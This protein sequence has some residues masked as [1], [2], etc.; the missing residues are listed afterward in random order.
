M[1]IE[2]SALQG[3]LTELFSQLAG[4]NGEKRLEEFKL[5]LKRVG[6][7]HLVEVNRTLTAEEAV[8]ATGRTWWYKNQEELDSAPVSG[9]ARVMQEIFELD[10]DPTPTELK[11]EYDS[12]GLEPDLATLSAYMKDKPDAADERPIACKWGLNP[13]G[14]ASYAFFRRVGRDRDVYV[15]RGGDRW[16]RLCRFAGVR[17]IGSKL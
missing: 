17:K 10:Y 9:P 5:W 15:Y 14:T 8:N 11:A 12:R 7:G 6:F 13:D 4:K 16:N 2:V 3:P 1:S